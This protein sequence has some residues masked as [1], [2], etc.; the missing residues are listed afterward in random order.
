MIAIKNGGKLDPMT[1]TMPMEA[2][3][4]RTRNWITWGEESIQRGIATE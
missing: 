1:I 3:D 4:V 2:V